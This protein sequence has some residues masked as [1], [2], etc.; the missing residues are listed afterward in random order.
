MNIFNWR[1][2]LCYSA[3]NEYPAE[4][5]FNNHADTPLISAEEYFKYSFQ[6]ITTGK[7]AEDE[8]PWDINDIPFSLYNHALRNFGGKSETYGMYCP[9]CLSFLSPLSS[10]LHYYKKHTRLKLR[11]PEES[12]LQSLSHL[13][14]L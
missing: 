13:F 8:E 1:C 9:F 14:S 4:H 5:F 12:Q 10:S 2:E 3:T 11:M 6:L 7:S